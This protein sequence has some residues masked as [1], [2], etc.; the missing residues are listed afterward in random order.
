MKEKIG[1]SP[2]LTQIQNL[3]SMHIIDKNKH[4]LTFMH[5]CPMIANKMFLNL[6]EAVS[7]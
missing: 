7:G 2:E 4:F 6:L 1:L 5:F 3:V